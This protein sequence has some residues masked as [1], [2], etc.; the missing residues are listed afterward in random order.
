MTKDGCKV[1]TADLW[2]QVRRPEIVEDFE[3]EVVG[4]VPKDV[5][6][7]TWFITNRA[8]DPAVDKIPVN[9]RQLVGRVDNSACPS[10]EVNI[11]MT[12]VTPLEAKT[13]VPVLMMFGGLG[14]GGFPRKTTD[15][16]PTN[17]FLGFGGTTFT[18]P[19]STEQL[20][21]AG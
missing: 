17:R 15:P 1:T 5:P 21:A 7:V 18:D 6:K 13:P 20:I 12:L 11:Q 16:E 3:R 19:P 10:I 9:A 4:R 14:G 2:W 8:T